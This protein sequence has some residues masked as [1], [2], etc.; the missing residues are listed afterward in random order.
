MYEWCPKTR[1]HPERLWS[2][3]SGVTPRR[4]RGKMRRLVHGRG[5][6]IFQCPYEKINSIILLSWMGESL[7]ILCQKQSP[8][9][10]MDAARIVRKR[11]WHKSLSSYLM[12]E[13]AALNLLIGLSIKTNHHLWYLIILL[14]WTRESLPLFCREQSPIWSRDAARIVRKRGRHKSLC[15]YGMEEERAWWSWRRGRVKG[16]FQV[17]AET[18]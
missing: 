6:V 14:W 7:P 16:G 11:G 8:N 13:Q 1:R 9:L 17:Q 5:R 18:E 3:S 15:S 10:I 4:R 2:Q 12:E